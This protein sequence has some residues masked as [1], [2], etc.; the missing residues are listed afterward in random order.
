[1]SDRSIVWAL[2][3][4]SASSTTAA[5]MKVET[6]RSTARVVSLSFQVAPSSTL[7]SSST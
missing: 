4:A 5:R 6:G 7:P 3:R 2:I 1:M